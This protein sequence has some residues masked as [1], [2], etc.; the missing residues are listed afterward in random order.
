MAV[1]NKN[2][3]PGGRPLKF[4]TEADLK[5]A[6][7]KYFKD[8]D[9]RTVTVIKYGKKIKLPNPKPYTMTGL[10]MAIGI[11]RQTLLRWSKVDKFCRTVREARMR[12]QEFAE[13]HLF[14]PGI[15]Q[16]VIFNLKNNHPGWKD[17][18]VVIDETKVSLE[19]SKGKKMSL[20]QLQEH[21]KN[22]FAQKNA[23][24]KAR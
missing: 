17:E 10:A 18:S 15:A 12:C 6:I 3:H 21:F 19:D 4:K 1:P 7:D 2:T 9:S 16:G 5:K 23:K 14:T 8:C 22:L 13:S 11:D 20:E 24:D